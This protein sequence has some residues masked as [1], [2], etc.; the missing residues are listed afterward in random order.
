MKYAV[1]IGAS[2]MK[3]DSGIQNWLKWIHSLFHKSSFIFSQSKEIRL[4]FFLNPILFAI[5]TSTFSKLCINMYTV[6]CR[7]AQ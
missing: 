5:Y 4:E 7:S 3:I 6:A 1:E 2:P